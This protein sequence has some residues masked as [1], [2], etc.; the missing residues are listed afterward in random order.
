MQDLEKG[1][2]RINVK[3]D[4]PTFGSTVRVQK[5]DGPTFAQ[6]DGPTFGGNRWQGTTVV[7]DARGRE[8]PIP[9]P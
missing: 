9:L 2:A 6:D 4:G 1:I 3:D 5:D 8:P 7:D